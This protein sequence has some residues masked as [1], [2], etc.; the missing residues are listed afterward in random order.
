MFALGKRRIDLLS[1]GGARQDNYPPKKANRTTP[2]LIALLIERRHNQRVDFHP[3]Q[4][5]DGVNLPDG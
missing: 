2:V 3:I 1:V 4:L 5:I